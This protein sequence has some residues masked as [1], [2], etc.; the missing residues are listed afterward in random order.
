MAKSISANAYSASTSPNLSIANGR[1]LF[2]IIGFAGIIGFAID[3]L[4]LMAPPN[5]GDLQWRVGIIRNFSDRSFVLLLGMTFA[6]LGSLDAKVLRKQLSLA[7][8]GVGALFLVLTVLSIRDGITLQKMTTSNIIGQANQA[9]EQIE[10]LKAD[11]KASGK[12][13]PDQLQQAVNRLTQQSN[14]LQ[15]NATTQIAK[16]GASSVAN[17]IVMG[18]AMIGIGR[19]GMRK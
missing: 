6:M 5:F 2:R 12:V 18:A 13:T 19:Y 4:I 14:S 11:P 10:K 7:C 17:L 3:A 9:Q 1:G 15:Q 8:L 16:T